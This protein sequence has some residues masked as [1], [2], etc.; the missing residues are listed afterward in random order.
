MHRCPDVLVTEEAVYFDGRELPWFIARN[1][2]SFKPGGCDD[3][4]QLTITFLVESARFE[5]SWGLQH[6]QRWQDLK[7]RVADEYTDELF[8]LLKGL[9]G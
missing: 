6:H 9:H 3:I 8:A 5:A 7:A 2:V 4:N 1:G